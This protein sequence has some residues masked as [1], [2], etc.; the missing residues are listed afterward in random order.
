MATI[1]KVLQR[2]DGSEVKIVATEFFGSGLTRS[3]GVDVFRRP[4]KEANW[5]LCN[6]RPAEGWK[7]MPRDQY[8]KEGRSEV[9]R[10]TSHGEILKVV[11]MLTPPAKEESPPRAKPKTR[12]AQP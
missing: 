8:I 7:Q 6:D 1:S 2:E 9:L 11:N 3:V 12:K 5:V 4:N 10:Y